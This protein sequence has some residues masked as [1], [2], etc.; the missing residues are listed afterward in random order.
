MPEA[1]PNRPDEPDLHLVETDEVP[2]VE[3]TETISQEELVEMR[4][5]N[6][7]N[8]LAGLTNAE[9]DRL[10]FLR[11]KQKEIKL[12]PL[13]SEERERMRQLQ[14]AVTTPNFNT[15]MGK[16]LLELQEREKGNRE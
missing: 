11:N 13:T 8:I 7:K 6:S 14:L 15:L 16:E 2:N 9:L 5:L 1:L 4:A 3:T 10:K 12:L